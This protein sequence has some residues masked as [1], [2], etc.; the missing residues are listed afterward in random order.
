[1][2]VCHTCCAG[3]PLYAPPPKAACETHNTGCPDKFAFDRLGPRL[4]NLLISP[5]VPKGSV[6][7]D[8]DGPTSTSKYDLASIPA[9]AKNLFGL[10]SF[11]TARDAWSGSFHTLIAAQPRT[12]TPTHLPAPPT[13]SLDVP[14]RHGCGKAEKASRRQKRHHALLDD[15]LR[16]VRTAMKGGDDDDDDDDNGDGGG[17]AASD[18]G[19]GGG[20]DDDDDDDGDGGE[21]ADDGDDE[22]PE[23]PLLKENSF[24][25]TKG[26][27][28]M[29]QA[30][31]VKMQRVLDH[32]RNGTLRIRADGHEE[33]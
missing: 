12:D 16:G 9:T 6:F 19:G 33:L 20:D 11:L 4:A 21:A 14:T 26:F 32:L 30:I 22:G 5:R 27:P 1:M 3:R 18:D 17:T 13:P 8:P 23:L 25:I 28:A 15:I 29:Q 2:R 24:L 7:R 10:E 31:A